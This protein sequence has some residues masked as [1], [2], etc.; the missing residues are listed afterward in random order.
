MK[1][2]KRVIVLKPVPIPGLEEPMPMFSTIELY[3]TYP[4][5][6][7]EHQVVFQQGNRFGMVGDRCYSISEEYLLELSRKGIVVLHY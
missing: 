4:R 3:N 1:N 5:N 2:I 7:R 6:K